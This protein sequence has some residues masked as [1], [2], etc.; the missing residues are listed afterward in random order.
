V[1]DARWPPKSPGQLRA[2][3]ASRIA[4]TKN[5]LFLLEVLAGCGG[6][7]HLDII[8]PLEDRGYWGRCRSLIE[9]LPA[10]VTVAYV[11]EAAHADLQR[12]LST[13]DLMVLPTRGENFGH[14][15]VEALAAGCPVLLSDRTPWRH[16]AAQGVG[17]DV[18]LDREAWAGAIGE[19]LA[20]DADDH[21]AMR[22]R[23]REYARR[24]W[25]EGVSGD[26]SLRRLIGTACRPRSADACA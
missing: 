26:E 13:Y 9:R 24:V 5:L 22:S 7:V 19:C 6:R 25:Q 1:T 21:L 23:A 18:A 3:F 16:L 14:I 11:G 4:P 17:W 10:N 20:L 15:V 12:R 2:V 8:G